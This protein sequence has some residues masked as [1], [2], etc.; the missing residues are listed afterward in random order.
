MLAFLGNSPLLSQDTWYKEALPCSHKATDRYYS[1]ILFGIHVLFDL[2]P[3]FV[4]IVFLAITVCFIKYHS[5]TDIQ[6]KT[7]MVRTREILS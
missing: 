3:L 1:Y 2:A 7:T 4:T 6:A 5:F